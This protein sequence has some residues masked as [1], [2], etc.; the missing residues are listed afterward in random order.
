MARLPALIETLAHFDTREPSAIRYAARA[1]RE[2]KLLSTAKSGLGAAE[3][4]PADAAS[5]VVALNAAETPQQYVAVTRALLSAAPAASAKPERRAPEIVR[6]VH[7]AENFG[8]ALVLL[9]EAGRDLARMND[10]AMATLLA[11]GGVAPRD[12]A[13]GEAMPDGVTAIVTFHRPRLQARIV[14]GWRADASGEPATWSAT[15]AASSAAAA[16][17]FGRQTVT[18]LDATIFTALH[19]TLFAEAPWAFAA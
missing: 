18:V 6:S 14:L 16:P 5:L 7:R 4:T 2:A 17:R 8:Q 15:F 12:S 9:V 1:L 13:A 3:M 11:A 19:R 10:P